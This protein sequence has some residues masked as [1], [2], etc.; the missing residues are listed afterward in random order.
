[1]PCAWLLRRFRR[2]P[3]RSMRWLPRRNIACARSTPCG[4]HISCELPC[5]LP[6]E[7]ACE[8]ACDLASLAVHIGSLERRISHL[9]RVPNAGSSDGA[10]RATARCLP[11]HHLSLPTLHSHRSSHRA[12]AYCQQACRWQS[13]AWRCGDVLQATPANQIVSATPP[14][15]QR[16]DARESAIP[17]VICTPFPPFP[18]LGC[19]CDPGRHRCASAS[20]P[21]A[22]TP[23]LALASPDRQTGC[24]H[25]APSP[26]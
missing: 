13:R 21:P 26:R 20:A 2:W 23:P 17:S 6:C 24:G 4:P 18:S 7:L 16:S 14:R 15:T 9:A 1:M 19:P 25:A 12:Q 8:L 10:A 5:E 3:S 22:P 11:G